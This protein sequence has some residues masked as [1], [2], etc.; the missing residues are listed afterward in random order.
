MHIIER[1]DSLSKI[2]RQRICESRNYVNDIFLNR[3]ERVEPFS[4]EVEAAIKNN[5]DLQSAG[6]YHD[7]TSLYRKMSAY[8]NVDTQKFLVTCGADES[9]KN[10]FNIFTNKGDLVCFPS[11]TYGM[12]HVYSNIY[13]VQKLT[14]N[15]NE[16][17]KIDKQELYDNL[18]RIKVLFLPNPNHIED[19]FSIE[20]I[21]NICK[22]AN[23]LVVVDETYYGFGCKTVAPLIDECDNLLVI[24][25]FSKT[26]GLPSLRVGATIGQ[27]D[28]IQ[29]LDAQRVAYEVS[30]VCQQ[31]AEFFLDN[32]Q[33]TNDYA[34]KCTEGRKL[35]I[36]T[37]KGKF[38]V[39]GESGYL[40]TIKMRDQQL[41]ENV[42]GKLKKSRIHVGQFD[43]NIRI[44]IGPE[45]YM[46]NFLYQ[47]KLAVSCLT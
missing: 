8:L 37:L 46:Q 13:G 39:N 23:G 1:F 14:L 12:Y 7:L 17:F 18:H 40:V 19:C 2:K 30:S 24:R 15:Y 6:F 33:I 16:D 34:K 45:Q 32:M 35:V 9:I 41:A 38:K 20:E 4:Q 5:L 29:S 21:K 27:K 25:S 11:P 10:I 36:D 3:A 31:I 22:E 42:A 47:F 26:F 28:L 43:E 44:T